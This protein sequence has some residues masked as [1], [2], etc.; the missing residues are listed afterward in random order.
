MDLNTVK[1]VATTVI[2]AFVVIGVL[3]AII[4]KKII[5]KIISLLLAAAIIFFAWQQRTHVV[6]Y[7]D[8]MKGQVCA[9]QPHFFGITVKLPADWCK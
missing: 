7:A 3:A 9:A 8:D 4:I 6:N 2:I 1:T 5:G